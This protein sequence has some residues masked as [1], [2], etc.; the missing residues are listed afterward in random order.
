MKKLSMPARVCHNCRANP[1]RINRAQKLDE[2]L[3]VPLPT[4]I[5]QPGKGSVPKDQF[6]RLGHRVLDRDR[7]AASPPRANWVHTTFEK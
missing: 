5:P 1:E 7:S 2:A 3:K 4:L 6:S